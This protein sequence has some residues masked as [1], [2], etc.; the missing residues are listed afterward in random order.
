MYVWLCMCVWLCVW[1]YLQ[2]SGLKMMVN[3]VDLVWSGGDR[4][5]GGDGGCGVVVVVMV[6]V[7]AW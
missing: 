2:W 3:G 7:D 4:A 1:P 5:M 6:G